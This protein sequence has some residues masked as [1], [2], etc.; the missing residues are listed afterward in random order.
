MHGG[1]AGVSG[2]PLPLCRSNAEIGGNPDR[3]FLVFAQIRDKITNQPIM[4]CED[5]EPSI[6]EVADT[7]PKRSDPKAAVVCL[8]QCIDLIVSELISICGRRRP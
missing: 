1:V 4:H 2:R 3:T 5:G 7:T 6:L 8:L